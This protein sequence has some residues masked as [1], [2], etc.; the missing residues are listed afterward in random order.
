MPFGLDV[1]L[2]IATNLVSSAMW[3][4]ARDPLYADE[5]D[6]AQG[7]PRAY[8]AAVG[9]AVAGIERTLETVQEDDLP[10]VSSFLASNE[11]RQL[12]MQLFRTRV[13]VPNA[14]RSEIRSAARAIWNARHGDRSRALDVDGLVDALVDACDVMLERGVKQ[15]VLAAH[16]AKSAARHALL[17]E[18]LASIE[19]QV[20]QIGDGALSSARID[21]FESALRSATTRAYG[22]LMP[23][24]ASSG[25]R[26]AIADVYVAPPFTMESG[27]EPTLYEQLAGQTFRLVVVGGPGVGKTTFA[28]KL[29]W[30]LAVGQRSL[31]GALRVAGILVSLRALPRY[32]GGRASGCDRLRAVLDDVVYGQLGVP[33]DPAALE[34]LLTAGRLAVVFDGVDELPSADERWRLHEDLEAFA[35]RFPLVPL[36]VTS[37]LIGYDTARLN[38]RRFRLARLGEYT[39]EQVTEFARRWFSANGATTEEASSLARELLSQ[40][41]FLPDVRASPLI[42]ALLCG[43]YLDRGGIPSDRINVHEACVELFL[44]EWD[45]QRAIL[46]D[47]AR[48]FIRPMLCA[49]AWW[50]L[51]T[52]SVGFG[53]TES[54]LAHKVYVEWHSILLISSEAEACTDDFLA[55]CR[56]RGWVFTEVGIDA[57]GEAIFQFTHRTF[58]EFFAAE[59]VATKLARNVAALASAVAE[60]LLS[61]NANAALL[62][63]KAYDRAVPDGREELAAAMLAQCAGQPERDAVECFVRSLAGS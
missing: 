28:Q 5:Y 60:L 53:A 21:A 15:N 45:R 9:D 4:L 23:G 48:Q 1:L 57:E 32:D 56:G 46:P 50:I 38:E 43:I 3:D 63:A 44:E 12:V 33:S 22:S 27:V 40:T 18:R 19:R 37:R 58:L 2:A 7:G 29:C 47:P 59:H 11:M 26:C 31:S 39:D 14:A 34:Y 16:E 6:P 52:P 54:A 24:A 17:T 41:S 42:L 8:A 49:V 61:D 62:A 30:D 13:T 10:A 35:E 51:T 25:V 20:A 55:F 36:V